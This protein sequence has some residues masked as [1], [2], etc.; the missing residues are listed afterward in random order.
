MSTLTDKVAI[1]TGASKGIGAGIARAL[2]AK[3]AAVVVN[4]AS[5]QAGADAVVAEITQAGGRALAVKADVTREDEVTALVAAAV[6]HFGRLD[7]VVNNSGIYEF[8]GIEDVSAEDYRKIFDINVLG[9]L[10]VTKAALPHLT[11]GASVINI[12]S[13]ITRMRMPQGSLYTATKAALDAITRVLAVE[14]GPR[15][16]R[17][18]AIAPGMTQT[19]GTDTAGIVPG[20]DFANQIVAHT[21]LGRMGQPG[22]IATAAVFLASDDAAWITGEVIGVS[23]GA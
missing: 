23:G 13:N 5:S 14:L 15:K 6:E 1:V 19:E 20:S 22:D 7:V 10:L 9:P 18:N 16:V 17:I 2:A 21:P 4:Y 11:E 12:S 8:R 3:G